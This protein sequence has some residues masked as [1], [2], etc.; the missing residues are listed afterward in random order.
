MEKHPL[1]DPDLNFPSKRQRQEDAHPPDQQS[2]PK[3]PPE[4]KL[5]NDG[6]FCDDCR[7]VNWSSLPNLAADG[8]MES[9]NLNLRPIN[10][11]VEELRNSSCKIC[12][13]LSTLKQSFLDVDQCVLKALPLSRHFSYNGPFIQH[14]GMSTTR[15]ILLSIT[16]EKAR[17]KYCHRLP[18]LAVIRRDDLESRRILPSSVDYNKFKGL[19][20][21]CEEKHQRCCAISS[22]PNV[23]GLEVIDTRTQA[24]IKAPDRCKYLAL[25]YV[26]GKQADD[27][28]VHNINDSPL[29]IKDAISVTKA[30]GYS[31]LWVDRYVGRHGLL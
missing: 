5:H 17:G 10:A 12:V 22:Q 1:D 28:S 29:V 9:E 25:S 23:L 21:I 14:T 6:V 30:M 26:W 2:A 8:S 4:D 18:G 3:Q 11:K 7:A 19:V 15:C 24:V 31:Y 20:R 27:S 13:F 16:G